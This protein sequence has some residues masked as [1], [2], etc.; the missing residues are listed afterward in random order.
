MPSKVTGRSVAVM[1][2]V[3]AGPIQ[4][5]AWHGAA[6]VAMPGVSSFFEGDGGDDKGDEGVGPGPTEG[7]VEGQAEEQDSGEV[8]AEEGLFGVGHGAG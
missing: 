1:A 6:G 2:T 8:G 5:G 4:T 7:A 3:V